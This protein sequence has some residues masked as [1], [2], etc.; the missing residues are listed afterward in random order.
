MVFT[1]KLFS[2]VVSVAMLFVAACSN[3]VG[4]ESIKSNAEQGTKASNESTKKAEPKELTED[5]VVD[6]LTKY[7]SDH[8][9]TYVRVETPKGDIKIRLYKNTP[10]HRANFLYLT[11]KK[12]FDDTWFYRVSEGHVIQAG[13]TDGME[14]VKKRKKIGEYRLPAEIVANNYHKYGAVAMARSYKQNPDK[15]SNPFEF[16][17]VLGKSYSRRE[18][19]LLAEK[20]DMTFTNDQLDFYS[21]TKGSPHLDGQLTVFGEVVEGMDVAEAISKVEVDEGEWPLVNLPIKVK[22]TR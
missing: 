10:L 3:S 15:M 4:N 7:G 20:H 9:E 2:I 16:Y 6:F 5:N 1:Q 19:E 13:N 22:V 21:T 18:L 11:S 17:I 14:T 8:G 12:Y